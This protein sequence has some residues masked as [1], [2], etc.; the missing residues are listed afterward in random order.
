MLPKTKKGLKKKHMKDIFPKKKKK[1][2]K[3]NVSS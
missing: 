3:K 1:K 2:K